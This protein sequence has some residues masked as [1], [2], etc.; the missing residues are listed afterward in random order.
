M[1]A[2]PETTFTMGSP[3]GLGEEDEWPAHPVTLSAFEIDKTEVTIGQ[4]WQCVAAGVCAPPANPGLHYLNDPAFDNYPMANLPWSEASRYCAWRGKRLPTE[5]EWEMAAAW[6]AARR[7][8]L[9][10]PWGNAA[11]EAEV[12]VGQGSTGQ[13]GVVGSFA[14]DRSP[15]GALDMAGNVGEWVADWY[16]VD[17][18][19]LAE[20]ANPTGPAQ[21]RGEGSG[22]VVRG[23]SFA[24]DLTEARAANRRHQPEKSGY[25]NVGFRCARDKP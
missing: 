7:A 10:W 23:G 8:K 16:K 11:P 14:G 3:Q 2:L 25:P 9:Q 6:D 15:A 21:R 18:Y 1:V 20:D 19:R 22:K 24:D 17:Y 13:A 5:A 4:Y 12:N